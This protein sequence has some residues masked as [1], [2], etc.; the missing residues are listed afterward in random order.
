M[1]LNIN[2]WVLSNKCFCDFNNVLTFIQLSIQFYCLDMF[3]HS[4]KPPD[5]NWVP[6]KNFSVS[7]SSTTSDYFSNHSRSLS[8]DSV[9]ILP[10]ASC[11]GTFKL[12]SLII[13]QTTENSLQPLQVISP[14]KTILHLI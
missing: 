11:S 2:F 7:N 9:E 13:S 5:Q 4:T 10:T 6:K 3:Q 12:S 14:T 8:P 1:K